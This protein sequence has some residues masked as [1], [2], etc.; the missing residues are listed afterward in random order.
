MERA[1]WAVKEA[2]L[3]VAIPTN[4][5]PVLPGSVSFAAPW[6][7]A[8]GA[9]HVITEQGGP[10]A[11]TDVLIRQVDR[12]LAA[13][14]AAAEPQET[15]LAERLAATLR[16]LVAA[17]AGAS[18]AD[19]A[20][21]RAAVHC[22]TRFTRDARYDRRPHRSLAADL[23]VVNRISRDLGREDLLISYDGLAV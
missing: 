22:F 10:Q 9:R 7:G 15:Q 2:I 8:K 3:P 11:G 21:V 1:P 16:V 4:L 6:V 5:L 20:R 12:R 13:L 23:G 14:R 18:A 17:T 19:R